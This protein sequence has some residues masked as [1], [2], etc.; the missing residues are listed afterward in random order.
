M[1]NTKKYGLKIFTIALLVSFLYTN[2]S[3]C[4]LVTSNC[5]PNSASCCCK[6]HQNQNQA[7]E[8]IEKKCCCEFKEMTSQPADIPLIISDNSFKNLSLNCYCF[9]TSVNIEHPEKNT[10]LIKSLKLHS[11]PAED[12]NILNS[13]F[14]I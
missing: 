8:I 10:E 6:D 4:D 12:L 11:P 9:N 14:R 13:N 7:K 1:K 5:Q 3:L 2:L